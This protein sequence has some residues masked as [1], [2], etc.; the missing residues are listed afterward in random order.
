M[1]EIS[2]EFKV[3]HNEEENRFEVNLNGDVALIEY[4]W[5]GDHITFVH[6]EVPKAFSGKGIAG[7]MAKTALEF[8]REKHLRVSSICTFMDVYL[9]RHPEYN[10]LLNK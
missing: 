1:T 9:K 6:T 8:A 10:D 5:L 3:I 2:V 7:Q 4:L